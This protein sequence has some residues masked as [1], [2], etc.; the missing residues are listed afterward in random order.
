MLCKK[1]SLDKPSD[2]FYTSNRSRCK[3]CVKANVLAYRNAN[4]ESARAYDRARGSLPHRVAARTAYQQTPAYAA[5]HQAANGRWMDAHPERRKAD[6]ALNN[7]V[8]DGRV[9]PWPLCAVPEC[10][11]QPEAHHPDY[12]RPLDVVWL[13]PGH[14][15]P[16]HALVANDSAYREQA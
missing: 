14:H 7:A 2:A 9:T 1:C 11:D 13:C 15:R 10:V 5:S 16:A 3:D 12:S 4:L 8:R 6:V